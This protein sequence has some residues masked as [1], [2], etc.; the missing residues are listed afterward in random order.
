M[1]TLEQAAEERILILDGAMGTM[2]QRLGLTEKDF[3]PAGM[4]EHPILLQGNNELLSLSM[5]DAIRKIHEEYLEAGADIVETNTFSATRIAQAEH[6]CEDLVREM[7]VRSSELAREACAKY[8]AMDPSKPRFVAG[9]IGPMNKTASLSPD[10]NDPGY[11]AVTFDQLVAAYKQQVEALLDGGVDILLV[12]TI[13]DTLNAKA[14]FYAIDEV[15]E[16]RGTRVPIMCSVTITDASGR[17]LSGQTIDAFLISMA[18]VELFSMGL[19]CALGAAQMRPYLEAIADQAN[20][21]VSVYP[22]AGLPDQMGEYRESPEVTAKLVGEFMAE[23][24]LNV[25]GGCCG[26]TPAHIAALAEEAKKHQP[27]VLTPIELNS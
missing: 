1:K 12:E 6:Q 10:V 27:R 24:W 23:G 8:T 20:C 25:V 14:A 22:N 3:H 9:A 16:E 21:R 18:H 5:P 26:T 13:F 2:I 7:N 4:E 19:N 15:F 11:R 17:T